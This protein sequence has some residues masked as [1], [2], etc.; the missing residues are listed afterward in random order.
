MFEVRVSLQDGY[1]M[2]GISIS[3]THLREQ[4]QKHV[5]GS[6][7]HCQVV[8]QTFLPVVKLE[9]YTVLALRLIDWA[10][11]STTKAATIACLNSRYG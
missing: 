5:D 3:Y 7:A 1:N 8:V 4:S 6:S 11:V 9:E 10:I 2:A